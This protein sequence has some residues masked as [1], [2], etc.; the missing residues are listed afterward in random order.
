ME[1]KGIKNAVEM[2]EKKTGIDLPD[3]K[4]KAL[5]D[6]VKAKIAVDD[7]GDIAGKLGGLFGKK[8]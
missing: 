1:I 3:E 4:L 5:V 8:K 7:I 6:G 2:V